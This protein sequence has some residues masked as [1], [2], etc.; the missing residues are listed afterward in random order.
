MQ[1]AIA[2]AY[3]GAPFVSPNPLVGC[4]VVDRN[5]QLLAT[6]YHAKYGADHAEVD[7]LKKLQ[8]DELKNA[9]LYVTL[10]PC[11][12]EG[13]TSSCAKYIATLPVKKIV[14]GLMD[15]NPLVSGQGAQIL[16]NAGKTAVLY[17]GSLKSDLEDVCEVFLKNYREK[18]I[19][20]AAK[21][22]SSLDGLIALKSGE[23]KWITAEASREFVH[24][25]RSRYDAIVVGRNTVEMDNPSLNIRHKK[26]TKQTQIIVIDPAGTLLRKI[27]SGSKF[28][29][30]EIH[31]AKNIFFITK[32]PEAKSEWQQIKFSN[33]A[34]LNQQLWTKGIRSVFIE[35]GALTYSSYLSAGLVDRL[36]LFMAPVIIGAQN[37]ISWSQNFGI[38]Q[39]E[40]K[41]Q[42]KNLKIK[43][44]RPD[45]YMTGSL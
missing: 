45:I 12:H 29:F 24:E 34:N 14:Y 40:Q 19:F 6:G 7:A 39:L 36:H 31:D 16:T 8:I 21:V 22:A 13:K 27:Q 26:I 23:S 20:V 18:K 43:E 15:P 38:A 30:L 1:L 41:L 25:L 33:L 32:E 44:F 37:G 5:H 9:T 2:V 17:E 11:A 42:L 28:K 10:E 3:E 4:T 35:G